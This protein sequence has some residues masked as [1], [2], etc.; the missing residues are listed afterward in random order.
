MPSGTGKTLSLL[1]L[2]VAYLS[3]S[4]DAYV[5]ASIYLVWG[6][7]LFILRYIAKCATSILNQVEEFDSALKTGNCLMYSMM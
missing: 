7:M 3:V 5:P 4:F 6:R 2:I 1:S